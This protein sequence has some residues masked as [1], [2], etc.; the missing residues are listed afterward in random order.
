MSRTVIAVNSQQVE[1]EYMMSDLQ[2][3]LEAMSQSAKE[4]IPADKMATMASETEALKASGIEGKAVQSCETALDFTLPNHLGKQMNLGAML[5]EG[6]VVVS[7]YR[8]GW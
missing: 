2:K 8:G 5:S 1:K 6:P 7:F 3:Q 4:N